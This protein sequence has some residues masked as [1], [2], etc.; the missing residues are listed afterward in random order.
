MVCLGHVLKACVFCDMQVM[1]TSLRSM[2]GM[3]VSMLHI[4]T[5]SITST[6]EMD[7]LGSLVWMYSLLLMVQ[8]SCNHQS[9]LVVYPIFCKGFSTI[10]DGW[11]WDFW[12][13][14]PMFDLP[15]VSDPQTP[16]P[17]NPKVNFRSLTAVMYMNPYGFDDKKAGIWIPK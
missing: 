3:G 7:D 9:R 17:P 5:M 10:P 12:T 15:C 2:M 11:P 8:K 4:V 1:D 16:S 14:N 6:R 13:I